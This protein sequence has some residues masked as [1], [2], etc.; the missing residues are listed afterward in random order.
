MATRGREGRRGGH[1]PDPNRIE[2]ALEG[3]VNALEHHNPTPGIPTI[4]Q[5]RNL[6]PPMFEGTID[7]EVAKHWLQEIRKTYTVFPCTDEQKVS[8][9]AYMFVGEAHE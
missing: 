7:L 6:R 4:Q 1:N 2:R 9:T 8:F 5:F 3:L